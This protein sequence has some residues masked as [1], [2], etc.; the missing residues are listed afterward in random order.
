MTSILPEKQHK[1][2]DI[3]FGIA[4]NGKKYIECTFYGRVSTKVQTE[5]GKS[6]LERQ[7]TK[8]EHFKNLNPHVKV[9]RVIEDAI[10]GSTPNR[11]NWLL[12]GLENGTI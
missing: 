3:S 7:H 5:E 9:T 8:L 10:S 11:F 6:G 2:K 12:E 1:N 4:S